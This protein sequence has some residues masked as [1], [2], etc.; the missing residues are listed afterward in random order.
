M[1]SNI[2]TE[3][4]KLS[5]ENWFGQKEQRLLTSLGENKTLLSLKFCPMFLGVQINGHFPNEI[6][7]KP[8][9]ICLHFRLISGSTG[10]V[11]KIS[12]IVTKMC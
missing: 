8:F 7:N 2:M 9:Q 6:L 10:I 12:W 3:K 11:N 1:T 5:R 4:K